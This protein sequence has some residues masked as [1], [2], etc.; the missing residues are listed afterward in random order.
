M[1]GWH[2]D[3]AA[4]PVGQGAVTLVEGSAFCISLQSGDIFQ[5]VGRITLATDM[6]AYN[7]VS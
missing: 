2:A 6:G 1:A 3:N 5:R 4:G 7:P